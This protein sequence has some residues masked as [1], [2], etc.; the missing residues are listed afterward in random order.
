MKEFWDTPARVKM[1]EA[2]GAV[3]DGR[4]EISGN[5][6]KCYS[7]SGNKYYDIT[8]DPDAWAIMA[9]DNGSYWK[10]YL[11]YPAVAFL[12]QKE[13]LP[14]KPELTILFKG[15]KWKD[16]NTQFKNDFDA[17]LQHILAPL[18]PADRAALDAYVTE[19]EDAVRKR[20]LALLGKKTKPPEGY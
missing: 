17:A 7:S 5:A 18:V 20:P 13:L 3:A 14:Y 10:G 16:I 8:F 9:N 12:I 4:L 11:G 1:Y 2:F 19:V 15:V 6:A